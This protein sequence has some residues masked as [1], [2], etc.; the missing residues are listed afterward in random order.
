MQHGAKPAFGVARP[1][2]GD[3]PA[4]GP[5]TGGLQFPPLDADTG[6]SFGA[7][8]PAEPLSSVDPFANLP[9]FDQTAGAA[10]EDNEGL[11]MT[12]A[13]ARLA[14]REA[15]SGDAGKSRV[16]GF[17]AS[18]HKIKEQVLPRLLERVDP[19]AAATLTKDELAEEVRPISGEVLAEL[20]ITLNRR[21]QFALEKVLV[22]ELLG[23]GP[24]E[25]L[26]GDPLITDIM[27]NGPDQTYVER[28]GKLELAKITFRDE[29]HLFQI[30]QR[31]VSK[32]GRRVDQTTPLADA[33][34]ADGSRVNVIVPPLSLRGTAISIRKFS[35]KPIT[36]DIMAK[37]G[38]MSERMATFLKIA[39]ACRFNVIISGG[40]GSGKTTMLNALSKM[41]D[42]G[43]RVVTIE[44]AAE[45]RLQQPHWLPL[46]TRPANLEGAGA[47]TIRDLVV[48]AL[49]MRPDRIILGEIRGSECFDMLAAMNTGHDGSMCTLHSNSPRE[50]LA[51]ME[52][53]VMMS[54]IKV[55]KE[56]ISKQ[57]ADSVDLI[58]QVK[59][60]RDGS[61]RVTSITEVIGM[62]GP[63]IITQELF[64]FDYFSEDADGKIIGD[65]T[66]AGLRPYTLEKARQFGF[67]APLLEACL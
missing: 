30:A 15:A 31:I 53:M 26:L 9:G 33:R 32:V 10:T 29:E 28:K 61:R 16:E 47:I 27:V 43:E 54:D 56:A 22:D 64:K 14:I 39:G 67:D 42:P 6:G 4:P 60:L 66:P 1:M 65:F 34:L 55:P 49:R 58:V 35:S 5:L 2:Q 48:N 50:A 18:I 11:R 23:L 13:M 38:S 3:A 59:R 20:R 25:E 44:D 40:T 8:A 57:I 24:L 7:G 62:E 36:L 51:R 17:E 37:G 63:V 46:E 52:N 45:L 41:I 21:E 19:E 12:D